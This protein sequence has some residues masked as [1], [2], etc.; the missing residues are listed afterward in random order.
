M[1]ALVRSAL[2]D[3]ERWADDRVTAFERALDG[4][5]RQQRG[6]LRHEHQSGRADD[7]A[8]VR[9]QE[10]APPPEQIGQDAGRD[11]REPV[12]DP[13]ER[14][15]LGD[16]QRVVSGGEQVE[17]EEQP[18]DAHRESA[19]RGPQQEQPRVPAEAPD[20]IEVVAAVTS[21]LR[22]DHEEQ[23]R[24]HDPDEPGRERGRRASVRAVLTVAPGG[25]RDHP[26]GHDGGCDA[27]RSS[28]RHALA[29][30]LMTSETTRGAR[31]RPGRRWA[32]HTPPW[33]IQLRR[34]VIDRDGRR[35]WCV[36]RRSAP[37]RGPA[38]AAAR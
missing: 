34:R 27:E 14:G 3:H 35:P 28:S 21:P 4:G 30:R 15:E 22:D 9:D 32:K 36:P 5:E 38:T 18:P 37:A 11:H 31:T 29:P 19:E 12:A 6:R 33:R 25:P 20:A 7:V 24:E 1:N 8:G 26:E 16:E 2:L 13:V 17:I 23:Q 10:H